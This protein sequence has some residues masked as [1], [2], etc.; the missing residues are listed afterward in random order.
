MS[1]QVF[2]VAKQIKNK[3]SAAMILTKIYLIIDWQYS[4]ILLMYH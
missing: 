4:V 2:T 3:Y 1:A